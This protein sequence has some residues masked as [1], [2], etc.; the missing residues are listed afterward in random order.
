MW[1]HDDSGFG[2]MRLDFQ[3]VYELIWNTDMTRGEFDALK[4]HLFEREYGDGYTY[5]LEY[6]DILQQA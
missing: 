4:D 1:E 2:F 6:I 5:I 3:L